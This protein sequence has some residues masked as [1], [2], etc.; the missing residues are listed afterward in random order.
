MGGRPTEVTL[1]SLEDRPTTGAQYQLTV[2]EKVLQLH[3]FYIQDENMAK[4]Q[5]VVCFYTTVFS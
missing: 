3:W 1:Q 4:I 5:P 2:Y